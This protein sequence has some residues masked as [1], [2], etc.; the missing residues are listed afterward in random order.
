MSDMDRL[1][2][3]RELVRELEAGNEDA[4]GELL[5]RMNA[6]HESSLFREIGRLTR[7][8]HDA[9]ARVQLDSRLV[10]I[11]ENEMPDARHRLDYVINKTEEAANKTLTV[12]EELMPLAS[13][14]RESAQ[15]MR[16]DWRRFTRREMSVTE[17]R[18]LS[19][20]V[21]RFLDDID[22]SAGRMHGGLSEVLMAQDFQDLSGQEIRKVIKRV[23]EVEQTLLNMIKVAGEAGGDGRAQ[24]AKSPEKDEKQD[25]GMDTR[26]TS[27]DE[28]D[29][30]LSSLGF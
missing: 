8:L 9:L 18:E 28:A 1:N 27:Q 13:G 14:I 19:E 17:F 12:V 29:D 16:T 10:G 24:T 20:R 23:Q 15:G 3:A 2:L 22:E 26:V 7:E 5:G 25:A 30:L 6:Q 11:A 4:A 21:S